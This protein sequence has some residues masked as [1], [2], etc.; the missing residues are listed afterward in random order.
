MNLTESGT[1]PNHESASSRTPALRAGAPLPGPRGL[2]GIGA[3]HPFPFRG[4]L[5]TFVAMADRYGPCYRVPLPFGQ[6]AVTLSE[7]DAVDRVLRSN[8]ENYPKASVYDGARLLLGNG[9]VTS[10]GSFWERQRRLAQP[11][12][13]NTR[14]ARYLHTMGDCTERL[15]EEWRGGLDGAGID[16]HA[17]MTRLTMNIVGRTLFGLDLS[18]QNSSAGEAFTH[19]LR[20]IGTRGPGNLQVPLWLPTPGNL[21]FRQALRK[22]DI[23]VYEII[24]R[25]RAGGAEQADHTLL[26]AFVAARDPQTGEGMSDQQLRDEVVTLYLAGHETTASLLTWTF[27]ALARE[28]EMAARVLEEVDTLSPDAVPTLEG[29]NRLTYLP[30]VLSEVLRLYPPA[31]T[32]ARN[33][34]ED[35]LVCGYRVPA[36]CFVLLSPFITHRLEAHWPKPQRFDPER[37]TPENS[38]G[39]H[40]FAYFPFSAGP[41]VCIGKHFSLYEAQL[42]L[43]MVLREFRV[44]V[45]DG[46]P[47][48][49]KSVG[50]LRPD[51]TIQARIMRR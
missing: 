36:G 24:R 28:P 51:R 41:R 31:W 18:D 21:R 27:Y 48:G 1:C 20:G 43:A 35:D 30:R 14:L 33:V 47:V 25:F 22:L 45:A 29:I 46:R 42:V 9:L 34:L 13:K 44:E 4:I 37:F 32:I 7:P 2:P 15:L 10:E 11:A 26:G 49:F 6:T 23:L 5:G 50:T 3:V 17:A 12:F 39:R 40:P 16:L 19:A 38:K 8:R